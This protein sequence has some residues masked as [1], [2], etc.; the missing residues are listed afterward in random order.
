LSATTIE[1]ARIE[2]TSI[3][4]ADHG[5]LTAWV[6]LNGSGWGCGFGGYRLDSHNKALDRLFGIVWGFMFLMR[7]METVGVSKWEDLP[8]KYVRV[9]TQGLGGGIAAIGHL[10]EDKWFEPKTDELL[11]KLEVL[12]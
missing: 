6:H 4:N 5:V 2:S 10:I 9:R 11:K 7:V 8:G 3:S 1:N 12:S